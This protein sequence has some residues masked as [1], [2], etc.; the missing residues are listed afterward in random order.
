MKKQQRFFASIFDLNYDYSKGY[1]MDKNYVTKI[2]NS[3]DNKEIIKPYYDEVMS[4]Q[5]EVLKMIDKKYDHKQVE[6][7]KYETWLKKQAFTSG[8]DKS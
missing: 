1:I 3:L 8:D 6:K 4:I 5:K 2:F 7:D